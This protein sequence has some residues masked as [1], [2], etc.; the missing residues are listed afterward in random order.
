MGISMLSVTE[1][2]AAVD[3]F[4]TAL[5]TDDGVDLDVRL[6]AA[7]AAVAVGILGVLN[8]EDTEVVFG[9]FFGTLTRLIDI[10]EEAA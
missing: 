10:C 4:L 5:L 1:S 6:L 2:A 9:V 3:E 7:N 8:K